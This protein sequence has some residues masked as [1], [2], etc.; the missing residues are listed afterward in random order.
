MPL[1]R[2]FG[3]HKTQPSFNQNN[4]L[5]NH[6]IKKLQKNNMCAYLNNNGLKLCAASKAILPRRF[7]IVYTDAGVV[8]TG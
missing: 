2:N 3:L 8:D 4:E 1:H 5:C 7:K 6:M